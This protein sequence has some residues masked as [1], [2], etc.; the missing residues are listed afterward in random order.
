MGTPKHPVF[1]ALAE[2][3]R[4]FNIPQ[5]EFS[6][7]PAPFRQDQTVTPAS[8]SSTTSG[9]CRYSAIPSATSCS[10]F[11]DTGDPPSAG[12]LSTS[13]ARPLQLANFWQT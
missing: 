3:V 1:V 5:Y 12:K 9:L 13:P 6:D 8:P 11:A 7:L 2:T 4:Q 10:A